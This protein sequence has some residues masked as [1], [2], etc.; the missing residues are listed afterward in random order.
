MRTLK[1]GATALLAL[2][3]AAAGTV[4]TIGAV[5]AQDDDQLVVG[6]SWNNYNEERWA[7]ADEVAIKDTIEELG[8]RYV[9]TNA[10]SSAAQQADDI[11]LLLTLGVDAL[12]VLAQ[13]S[14]AIIPAVT[15]ALDQGVPVIAYD[16]LIEDP[17]TLYITFD[18]TAVGKLQAE[19]VF[20]LVPEGRYAMIKGNEA[21]LNAKVFLREG[22]DQ[23]IGEAVESGAIEI[24]CEPF[25]DNWEPAKATTNMEQCLTQADNDIDAVL[26]MN[27]GMATGIVVALDAQGLTGIPLSGQDGDFAALNRVANGTQTV[28]VWK[29]AFALGRTAAKTAVDLANGVDLTAAEAPSDLPDY[30][31]PPAGLKVVPFTTPNGVELPASITL[32]PLAVTQE[33]FNVPIDS[34]WIPQAVACQGVEAGSVPGC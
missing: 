20:K 13:D 21:D 9:S 23:A 26:S 19:E 10:K 14:N 12:I 11:D 4:A 7:R 31:T 8:G 16:R 3:V 22:Y 17:R 24:V 28:S 15:A 2:T 18:N 29:D 6:V 33:N 32:N 25:T 27:D 34:G 5:A 30:A 1:K